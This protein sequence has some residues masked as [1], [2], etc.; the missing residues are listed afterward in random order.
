MST[1]HLV[2][3]A[4][5]EVVATSED[6]AL[7]EEYAS[8]LPQY[9]DYMILGNSRHH[10][11]AYTLAD[12]WELYRN[13]GGRQ[14][15]GKYDRDKLEALI[16]SQLAGLAPTT[17]GPPAKARRYPIIPNGHYPNGDSNEDRRNDMATAKKTK[18]KKAPAEKAAPKKT[19]AKKAPAKKVERVRQNDV[20]HPLPNSKAG[21]VWA[22]ADKLSK[23]GGEPAQRAKV[24]EEA[25]KNKELSP[26][27]AAAD[28]QSWR[29]FHGLVKPRG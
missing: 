8:T 16:V 17:Q 26:A 23:K 4:T 5:L 6:M 25:A 1:G 7:L 2:N 12:L 22:I 27:G 10:L 29:R 28:F 18:A 15:P 13:T 11:V 14:N 20:L 24:L 3:N 19:A 9:A 21:Q